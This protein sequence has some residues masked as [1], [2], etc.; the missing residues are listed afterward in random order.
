MTG[1][2]VSVIIPTRNR[3]P[4]LSTHALPSALSQEDVELEVVVVDDALRRRHGRARGGHR[5]S[6]RPARTQRDAASTA[7]VAQRRG[8]T[9]RGARGSLSWTTTTCGRLGSSALSSTPS[10]LRAPHGSTRNASSSTRTYAPSTCTRSPTRRRCRRSFSRGNHV[11]GGGSNVIVRA[12]TFREVG[13]FDESLRFFED[14]DLWLRLVGVTLPAACPELLVARVEHGSNMLF[15]DRADVRADFERLRAKHGDGDGR[16]AP[17]RRGVD[18]AR[19]HAGR[20]QPAG[21]GTVR[22]SGNR[23]SQPRQ[24][25]GGGR[26]AL[27]T[28]WAGARRREC[29]G[30]SRGRRIST[31]RSSRA[32][33]GACLA[34]RVRR[35]VALARARSAHAAADYPRAM[36]FLTAIAVGV[37]VVTS[38]ASGSTGA[39]AP[40]PLT[41]APPA[42]T[43][44][45]AIDVTNANRRLFLDDARD[46]QL[47]VVEPLKRELW[48]EGG[49]NVVVIGGHITIDEPARSPPTRTTSPSKCASANP[50]GTVASRGAAGRRA[51]RRRRDRDREPRERPDRERPRRARPRRRQGRPCRLRPGPAWSRRP[52]HGSVHVQP[53]GA[54]GCSSATTTARSGRST[55]RRVDIYGAPGKH[56]LW[57]IDAE[58]PRARLRR[59]SRH[60]SRLQGLGVLRISGSTRSGTGE[61]MPGKSTGEACGGLP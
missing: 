46:Y 15:R 26:R 41:W 4:M 8:R 10:R 19:A 1:P 58:L 56:L 23:S 44:P 61:R 16:G 13:T 43:D 48:I 11:P 51:L 6:A 27:R 55:L 7:R 12:D 21:F 14:W 53:P 22:P 35:S 20:A 3:W 32:A 24:R 60:R 2:E 25:S 18:R 50:S 47:N 57:Q 38:A 45:I 39:G 5:R 28:A 54:K 30:R 36:R 31:R 59:A 33:R 17:R 40:T 52:P 37:A 29:F 42:L 49:R 34:G 9:R